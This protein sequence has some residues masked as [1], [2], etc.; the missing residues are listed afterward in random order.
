MHCQKPKRQAKCEAPLS[1]GA[2]RGGCGRKP[3]CRCSPRW[4]SGEHRT[5]KSEA[6]RLPA[7]LARDEGNR[8]RRAD[9]SRSEGTQIPQIQARTTQARHAENKRGF[10]VPAARTATRTLLQPL[11]RKRSCHPHGASAGKSSAHFNP[12]QM[13]TAQ[14]HKPNIGPQDLFIS[15]FPQS[16]H[17]GMETCLALPAANLREAS[18]SSPQRLFRSEG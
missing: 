16:R 7:V 15:S 1:E 17:R 13:Q 4:T 18:Q 2:G 9:S 12:R 14:N 3:S 5:E 8:E 6:R 11:M 10:P